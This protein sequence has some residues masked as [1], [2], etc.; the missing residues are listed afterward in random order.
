MAKSSSFPFDTE[1]SLK[2]KQWMVDEKVGRNS[3]S[4]PILP[5]NAKNEFIT[6][7]IFAYVATDEEI[8]NVL[9]FYNSSL[10]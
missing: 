10:V 3:Q 2:W 1:F 7:S 9:L 6:I 8:T 4:F 5:N